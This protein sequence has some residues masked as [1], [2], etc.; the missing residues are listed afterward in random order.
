M[1]RA[2]LPFSPQFMA[3]RPART[4]PLAR[5]HRITLNGV[6]FTP[7]P[8]GAL[9]AADQKTLLVAD[10]HLEQGAALARRGVHVPP[11]DTGATLGLLEDVLRETKPWR[12]ILLGD[13]FHDRVGHDAIDPDARARLIAITGAVETVWISGNHDPDAPTHLGGACVSAHHLEGIQ[14][15]HEP[16]RGG[17]IHEVAGHLH[18]GATIVQ[19]GIATRAKCFIADGRRIILPAFGSYTGAL[20]VRSRAFD[21]LFDA[22]TAHVWMIGTSAIHKFPLSRVS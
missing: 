19:R 22:A 1:W 14:L 8:S 3:K 2:M 13:S 6:N 4:S 10:L 17:P 5:P 15:R 20:N 7:H 11:F 21:G 18:P 9:L 16:S 12:M